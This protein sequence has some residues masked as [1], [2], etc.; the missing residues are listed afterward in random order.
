M[1]NPVLSQDPSLME[2]A[3]VWS[4]VVALPATLIYGWIGRKREH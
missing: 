1:W 2:L 4:V 3:L